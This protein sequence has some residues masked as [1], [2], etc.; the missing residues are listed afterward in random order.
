MKHNKYL[1]FKLMLIVLVATSACLQNAENQIILH[2]ENED[3]ESFE[4]K[5][6]DLAALP[7]AAIN[8]ADKNGDTSNYEGVKL[9]DV[10]RAANVPFGDDLRGKNMASYLIAE[11]ADGYKVSFTLAELDPDFSNRTIILADRRDGQPL[12]EDK[13]KLRLVVPDE[14]K[15]QARWVKQVVKL[16]VKNAE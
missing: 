13:G 12:A 11:G 7:R 2:I 8:A 4:L 15:R 1:F 14:T 5:R 16:T 10:L 6:K 3:G 9:V